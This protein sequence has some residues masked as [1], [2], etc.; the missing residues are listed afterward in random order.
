M[1]NFF[2]GL[3]VGG[4]SGRLL[5]A[6]AF[7]NTLGTFTAPGCT[8]N[9]SG[10][11]ESRRRY[12]ALVL[13]ALERTGLSPAGCLGLCAAVSGVDTPDQQAECRAIFEEMG[14][15][16]G[17]LQIVNDCEVFLVGRSEPAVILIAGTGSIAMGQGSDRTMVRRGGWGQLLSDEG[18]AFHIGLQVLRAVGDHLDGRRACPTLYR[19]MCEAHPFAE[20]TQV[21]DFAVAH[22][23]DKP[24]VA[25]L[26]RL[27]DRAA[28][29]G[30]PTALEILHRAGDALYAILRDTLLQLPAADRDRADVL[31]WGSVLTHSVPVAE[32][33]RRQL[34]AEFG[35]SA[36]APARSALEQALHAAR[37][38]AAD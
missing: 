15:A 36:T 6:D 8:L 16:P 20:A 21:N 24:P 2:A 11:A 23:C 13:G 4:T 29:D 1:Q 38:L 25:D 33:V 17:R 37:G 18:S 27:A 30:D 3:D 10:Y 32:R 5:L 19:L 28:A 31:L 26:A 35:L 7:G 9:V 34:A 12:R 14:F 22:L